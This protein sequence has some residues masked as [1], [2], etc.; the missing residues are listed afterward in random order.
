MSHNNSCGFKVYH[1]QY[2]SN[3]RGQAPDQ[4]KADRQDGLPDF[5]ISV[6]AV[7]TR[8]F[9][10]LWRSAYIW[11]RISST[12]LSPNRVICHTLRQ[13]TMRA[14][15]TRRP[16]TRKINLLCM[17]LKPMDVMARSYDRYAS[18][19]VPFYEEVQTLLLDFI[20]IR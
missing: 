15:A 2:R 5:S 8:V 3:S 4:R 18:L 20:R 7:S 1:S 9:S 12:P 11:A 13:P 19:V 16:A 17:L 10:L 14:A 6:Y